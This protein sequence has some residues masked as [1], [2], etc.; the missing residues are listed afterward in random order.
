MPAKKRVMTVVGARPQFVKAAVV[1]RELRR[2]GGRA[3]FEQILVHTGQH[4]DPMLSDVFFKE[5]EIPAPNFHLG[6]GSDTAANQIARILER[7][8]TVLSSEKPD[9]VLVYGDTNS[10]L[11]ASLA[12]AHR[13]VP[14]IHVEAGERIYRRLNVPE[15]INRVLTDQCAA[16]CLTSTER[17]AARLVREGIAAER[18]Q[19]VGDPMYDL[20]LWASSQVGRLAAVTPESFGVR[21]G[22]YHLATIHRVENTLS[23]DV[24]RQL[25]EAL[26]CS[27]VPVLLPAHP[28]LRRLL[29]PSGWR[30]RRN[31][32]LLEP[33]G[34]FDFL[35]LLL[36][37]RTCITDSGGVNREAFFARRPCIV[38]MESSCWP[39]I[40]EAGWALEVRHPE[41]LLEAVN[42]FS[43]SQP[44]PEGLFGDGHSAVK[45]VDRVAAFLARGGREAAWHPHGSWECLPKPAPSP[46][47]YE[48]YRGLLAKLVERGYE[49]VACA[50]ARVLREGRPAITL[51]HDVDFDLG[52]AL[53]M[54][55]LEHSLGIRATYFVRLR[56]A[57]Y[58]VFSEEGAEAVSAILSLGHGLG[59]RS[60]SGPGERRIERE[61]IE[62]WFR[63]DVAGASAPGNPEGPEAFFTDSPAGWEPGD[64]AESAAFQERRPLEI[65]VHPIWWNRHPTSPYETLLDYADRSKRRLENSIAGNEAARRAGWPREL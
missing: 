9:A 54:A 42:T 63:T 33:L 4:Y 17:A 13:H 61:M 60:E 50:E 32:R 21:G 34:Y 55:R 1:S 38:P 51:R 26:D 16:L 39:Q 2:R 53:E 23:F 65:A 52:K 29:E 25:L 58:N 7:L 48:A 64:P 5:L 57:H 45:I 8:A 30:P 31:L 44:A 36:N 49:F 6:V 27:E 22:C 56:S 3:P 41:A 59:L 12:A 24:L 47:T 19:F 14:L 10:T 40:V 46:F 43:P 20:F 37:C 62:R 18:V 15:E 35:L 28:R 11:A